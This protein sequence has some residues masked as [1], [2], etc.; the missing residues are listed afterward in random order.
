MEYGHA[1]IELRLLSPPCALRCAP[2]TGALRGAETHLSNQEIQVTK[3][4]RTDLPFQ[5][6]ER[7]SEMNWAVIRQTCPAQPTPCRGAEAAA[8]THKE[9][10]GAFAMRKYYS[11]AAAKMLAERFGADL[12][13]F[14]SVADKA[15]PADLIE[16]L[17]KA[18]ACCHEASAAPER[19]QPNDEPPLP[20]GDGEESDGGSVHHC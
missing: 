8:D 10:G 5:S 11:T 17:R 14:L 12:G 18:V 19:S 9:W 4:L 6:E 1:V 20:F 13:K 2:K 7:F 16:L 15:D 3:H